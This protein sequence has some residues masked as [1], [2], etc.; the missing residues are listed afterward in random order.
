MIEDEDAKQRV[1][2]FIQNTIRGNRN[3]EAAIIYATREAVPETT[4]IFPVWPNPEDDDPWALLASRQS[5][6]LNHLSIEEGHFDENANW[7]IDF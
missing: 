4:E 7:V 2:M 5:T 1:Q 6:Q 3:V